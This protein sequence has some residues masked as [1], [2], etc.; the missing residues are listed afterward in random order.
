MGLTY[1]PIL[2]YV[3][4]YVV[5]RKNDEGPTGSHN[6]KSIKLTKNMFF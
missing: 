2:F 1:S 4:H 5:D 3:E 6:N